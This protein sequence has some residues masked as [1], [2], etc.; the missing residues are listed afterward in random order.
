MDTAQINTSDDMSWS[1]AHGLVQSLVKKRLLRLTKKL[2]GMMTVQRKMIIHIQKQPKC[3]GVMLKDCVKHYL[4]QQEEYKIMIDDR[5]TL[6]TVIRSII[7]E[8]INQ[9]MNDM[10]AV[11]DEAICRVS[12]EVAEAVMDDNLDDK[13]TDWMNDNLHDQLEDKI[14][15]V[16]DQHR[17]G[18]PAH[19]TGWP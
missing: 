4:F 17:Q 11:V 2:Y 5:P 7:R 13:I 14:R 19:N 18:Q 12:R 16:I 8:E 6:T 9:V 1:H 10:P 15:I 3:V